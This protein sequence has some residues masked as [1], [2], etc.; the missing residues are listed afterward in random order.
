MSYFLAYRG[1]AAEKKHFS[2]HLYMLG[3]TA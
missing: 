2:R 3:P 1:L